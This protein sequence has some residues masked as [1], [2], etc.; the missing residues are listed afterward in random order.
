MTAAT[1]MMPAV[2]AWRSVTGVFPI[3]AAIAL[4][5]ALAVAKVAH[6]ILEVDDAAILIGLVDQNFADFLDLVLQAGD[7]FLGFELAVRDL[8]GERL[9]GLRHGGIGAA[10]LV[11]KRAGDEHAA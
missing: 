6:V 8:L 3:D 7:R 4:D 9:Q 5:E 11:Q 10:A 2:V 1:A